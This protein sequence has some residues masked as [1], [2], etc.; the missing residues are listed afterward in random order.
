MQ[1]LSSVWE[2]KMPHQVPLVSSSAVLVFAPDLQ[3]VP[4]KVLHLRLGQVQQAAAGDGAEGGLDGA[5]L[6][7]I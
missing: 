3:A 4:G 6:L 1:Y 5:A 7:R 2:R